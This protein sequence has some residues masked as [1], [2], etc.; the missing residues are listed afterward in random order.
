MTDHWPD[1]PDHEA[2]HDGDLH[3]H[4]PL[5]HDLA[6]EH[7]GWQVDV[8]EPVQHDEVAL[9]LDPVHHDA[10]VTAVDRDVLADV[11]GVEPGALAEAADRLGLPSDVDGYGAAVLL[12]ELG[13]DA[14]V[15]HGD[16]DGLAAEVGTGHEVVLS[17]AA[18]LLTVVAVDDT[19]IELQDRT[20]AVTRVELPAFEDA[21]AQA[22]YAMV[23]AEPAPL[24]GEIVLET[25]P[26]TV[27]GMA[28]PPSS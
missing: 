11:Y 5:G 12:G 19:G 8:P 7:G 14:A 24:T 27:L 1:L 2:L 22:S 21:W 15:L 20:G 6:A 13:V 17:G 16:V 23:V 10:D 26:V 4:D 18:G 9:H 3:D 28:W 25:G